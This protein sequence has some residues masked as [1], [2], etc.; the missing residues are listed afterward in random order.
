MLTTR[1]REPASKSSVG[2]SSR[3]KTEKSPSPRVNP[4]W[5]QLATRVQA[6]LSVST[7]GDPYEREADQVSDRVI[8]ISEPL[9]QRT[10]AVCAGGATPCSHF[11]REVEVIKQPPHIHH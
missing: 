7:P 9:V 8:R 10:C 2:P 5:H 1:N 6:K 3:T 4:L 11:E